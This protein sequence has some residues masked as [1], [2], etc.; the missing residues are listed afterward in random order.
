VIE[1]RS[2]K[3]KRN[4]YG[5]SEGSG[6]ELFLKKTIRNNSQAGGWHLRYGSEASGKRE[7]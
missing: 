7:I 5:A 4:E 6:G 3:T 1:I 2:K